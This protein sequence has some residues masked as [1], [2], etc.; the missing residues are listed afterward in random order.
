MTFHSPH[1]FIA[2]AEAESSNTD[3]KKSIRKSALEMMRRHVPIIFTLKHLAHLT[4]CPYQILYDIVQR[5]WTPYKEFHILKRNKTLRTISA[6]IQP[7][8]DVQKFICTNILYSEFYNQNV[9]INAF[10]YKKE[11]NIFMHAS[12]HC[13]ARWLIKIDIKNFFPSCSEILVYNIFK[14]MGYSCLFSFELARLT[15]WPSKESPFFKDSLRQSQYISKKYSIYTDSN[16]P[17]GALPQG[18]PSSPPLSNLIFFSLDKKLEKIAKSFSCIYTRYADDLYFSSHDFS[19]KDGANLIKSVA[20]P[21]GTYGFQLNKEKTKIF[22]PSHRKCVTGL[23]VNESIPTIGKSAKKEI[24]K[25]LFFI[26][27]NGIQSQ[28]QYQNSRDANSFLR[29]LLGKINYIQ[30]IDSQFASR[31]MQQLQEILKN[32][33]YINPKLY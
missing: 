11:T 17:L 18:A 1:T 24:K 10:A 16:N 33:G 21:L 8:R 20:Q 5:K 4:N 26:K 27:K 30:M 28:A 22:N 15:T 14:K 9:Y 32:S 23:I 7:L 25:H 29:Y 2:K 3:Y 31:C 13:A 6:P 19:Y 12:M